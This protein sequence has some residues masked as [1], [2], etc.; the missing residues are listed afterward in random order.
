MLQLDLVSEDSADPAPKKAKL[1]AETENEEEDEE[2]ED[3][4]PPP[5]ADESTEETS[6]NLRQVQSEEAEAYAKEAKLLFF[7]A[8]AKASF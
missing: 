2:D 5:P 3:A 1:A 7:E 4:T 6:D 8:S